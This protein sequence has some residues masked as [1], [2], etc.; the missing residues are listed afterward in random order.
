MRALRSA[1]V[2]VALLALAACQTGG[3]VTNGDGPGGTGAPDGDAP[4]TGDPG[5]VVLEVF[6][7]G[8]FVP[9]GYHFRFVPSLTVYGDGRA[10]V[11]GP[12]TLQYPGAALPNL[13]E[14]RL[15]ADE[16]DAI[17]AAAADA[18]LLGPAPEYGTPAIAD[19]PTTTVTLGVGGET[20]VHAVYALDLGAYGMDVDEGSADA[21]SGDD[22]GI[23]GLTPRE[24]EA[25]RVLAGFLARA[26]AIVDGA[27]EPT[28]FVPDGVAYLALPTQPWEGSGELAPEVLPWPLGTSLADAAECAA[29]TGEDA[30]TLLGVLRG[31][32]ELTRFEQGGV[33]YEVFARPLLPH[34]S[35]CAD[36]G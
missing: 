8:G 22:V 30:A 36:L 11:Q 33:E 19:V 25:R 15:S 5:A 18:G 31:A 26:T 6:T 20:Y 32:N 27:G 35:G 21:G 14:T 34:Q 1:V 10:I 4:R 13:L 17:V 29:V 24:R 12:V 7:S 3:D 9:I 2:G 28:P 16:V 23:D